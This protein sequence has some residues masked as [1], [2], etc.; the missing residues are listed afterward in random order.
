M[1]KSRRE[2]IETTLNQIEGMVHVGPLTQHPIIQDQFGTKITLQV[3]DKEYPFDVNILSQ[4]PYQFRE[5]ETIHFQNKDYAQYPFVSQEGVVCIHTSQSGDLATKLYKDIEGLKC[6]VK[7]TIISLS[8]PKHYEHLILPYLGTRPRRNF[9]FTDVLYNFTEGDFG[10]FNYSDQSHKKAGEYTYETYLIQD[11]N[12]DHSN[13][14]WSHAYQDKQHKRYQGFYAFLFSPPHQEGEPR[15]AVTRWEQLETYLSQDFL[16]FMW[17]ELKKN[18]KLGRDKVIP[19]LLGYR[20]APNKVHW[21]VATFPSSQIPNYGQATATKG[22]YIGRLK[23]MEIHWDQT[24]DSSYE[25]FFGRGKLSDQLTQG[26]I[27]IIGVGAIGSILAKSLTRGGARHISLCDF[28]LKEPGNICRS[29]YNFAAGVVPKIN[30]L[31]ESLQAIS[32]FV[33]VS[34]SPFWTDLLIT[35]PIDNL[36]SQISAQGLD[37][38]DYIFDCSANGDML[39]LLDRLK[40]EARV[41]SMAISNQAQELVCCSGKDLYRKNQ[42][43]FSRLTNTSTDM[44]NP[45]G[46]WNPTF[47]AS[48]NDIA[49]LVEFALKQLNLRLASDRPTNNFVLNTQDQDSF[50]IKLEEF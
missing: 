6:W 29:E 36:F 10:F 9:L 46:C 24:H 15:F 34:H 1:K 25:L 13:C 16:S 45:T 11:F 26:K 3:E 4:Y 35:L 42:K 14:D 43:L 12:R 17:S 48:Y 44:Y 40:P 32:P 20:I 37:H 30:E 28:D 2:I 49:V 8:K 50:G 18:K 5:F 47:K 7:D 41:I 19:L 33:N 38:F 31:S 23:D 39:H 22:K 21:Q 27:L